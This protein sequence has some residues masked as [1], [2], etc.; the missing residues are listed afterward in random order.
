MSFD[1][2]PEFQRDF[3]KLSKKYRTL[4]QD[5][6][7]FKQIVA[8]G[9][10]SFD[11]KAATVLTQGDEYRAVKARLFCRALR[12]D[13]LRIIYIERSNA[14]VLF[15]ELYYKGNKDRE[16]LKRIDRYT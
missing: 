1:E 2:A 16:D 12:K 13:A 5:L 3:K 11:G 6:E 14:G 8:S 7:L 15:I 4:E 10:L 9:K